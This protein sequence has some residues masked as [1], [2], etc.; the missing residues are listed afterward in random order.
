MP[1]RTVN[2]DGPYD[3]LRTLA[4]LARGKYDPT[5]RLTSG[6]AW[7]A[8]RTAA[9]PVTLH[10]IHDGDRLIG[11]AWGE[12]A[13]LALERLPQIAGVGP[14]APW[15][16]DLRHAPD[17]VVAGLA[18]QL[19]G[20]RIPATGAVLDALFPAILEQ[21]V[22]GS[23]ARRAWLGLL[24]QHGAPAPSPSPFPPPSPSP[25]GG[26]DVG[27]PDAPTLR[28]RPEASL[29][30]RLPAYAYH[31]FGVEE[32][33]A[34]TIKR[35]AARADWLEAIVDEPT[36][37]ATGRLRS[38]PGIGPWTVAEV[39]VRALGD[40]DAV[41]VGDFHLPN[42]VAWAF[43]RVPRANDARMLEL[44]APYDGRRALVIRLLEASG[45]RPPRYGPRLS[46]RRIED[47]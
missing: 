14:E 26:P 23:E 5:L 15:S 7:L 36:D 32:R 35:A 34:A 3:L 41:S 28:L 31:P 11:E 24:R 9:G 38:L 39:A 4:P 43:A 19:P 13:E 33:R 12:G 10:V 1:T 16:G 29:L 45:L 27:H 8:L 6:S 40:P 30:A 44:L 42:L 25:A 18:R 37:V 22:T 2:F 17:A 20:I 46:P 47:L 21:K